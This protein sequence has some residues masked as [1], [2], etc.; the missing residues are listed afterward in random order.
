MSRSKVREPWYEDVRP[1]KSS[2]LADKEIKDKKDDMTHS[3]HRVSSLLSHED[4]TCPAKA[5]YPP[6][7][8]IFNTHCTF[9]LLVV[10]IFMAQ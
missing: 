2:H 4:N 9:E 10:V 7:S 6:I 3:S 1:Q 5:V 8:L